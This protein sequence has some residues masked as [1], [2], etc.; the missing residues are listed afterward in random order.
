MVKK[1]YKFP[2]NIEHEVLDEAYLEKDNNSAN[3]RLVNNAEWWKLE[4][5]ALRITGNLEENDDPNGRVTGWTPSG[6]IHSER[7]Y[8]YAHNG[9]NPVIGV[10]VRAQKFLIFHSGHTNTSGFY[11]INH[12]Y[13]GSV[14]Y[15]IEWETYQ[16]IDF[17][18]TNSWGASRNWN[19]PNQSSGMSK[20]FWYGSG[21]EDWSCA[22]LMRGIH[23]WR[24]QAVAAAIRVPRNDTDGCIRIK[25]K[26]SLGWIENSNIL[27]HVTPF[28]VND[29]AMQCV[30]ASGNK[31]FSNYLFKT[32]MHE[33]GHISHALS[34][35]YHLGIGQQM[36]V[37]SWAQAVEHYFT[38][39]YYATIA[40]EEKDQI[41]TPTS[42]FKQGW[43][44]SFFIDMIDATNQRNTKGNAYADDRVTGYS[45]SQIHESLK[46]KM[47]SDDIVDDLWVKYPS[48][49]SRV[50]LDLL[51]NYYD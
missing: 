16:S 1:N 36:V 28:T 33:L 46:T 41:P 32:L 3:G 10:K 34:A 7:W 6:T 13:S 43:Y 35:N 5:E 45:L 14:N 22:T 11:Q 40:M 9:Y 12:N 51:E 4:R 30:W 8:N 15:S 47:I 20:I 49:S 26:F 37:E 25:P 18:V 31:I 2:E 17:K 39:P 27:P 23:Y 42:G 38:L 50:H 24:Q 48:N 44:S 29:V 19:G 21:G